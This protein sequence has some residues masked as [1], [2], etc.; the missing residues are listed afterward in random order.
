MGRSIVTLPDGRLAIP[1][2]T[3]DAAELGLTVDDSVDVRTR[4]GI[5]EAVKTN[6]YREMPREKLFSLITRRD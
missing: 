3:K 2:D 6:P 5:L 1:L 4:F